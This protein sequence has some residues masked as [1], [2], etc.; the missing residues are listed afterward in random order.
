MAAAPQSQ[1]SQPAGRLSV[2]EADCNL[3]EGG[4]CPVFAVH[5]VG[6]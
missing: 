4:V 1:Q 5:N 6:M 3:P 2:V